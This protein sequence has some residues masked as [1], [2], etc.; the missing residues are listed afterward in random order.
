MW[1]KIGRDR[2]ENYVCGLSSYL[3]Q[4]LNRKFGGS[5]TFFAPDL[6]E[7]TSGLTSINPFDD[8]TDRDLINTLVNRLQEETGYQIRSTNFNLSIGDPDQTYSLRISTHLFHN[9][10]QIDGLVNAM[11]DIYM[12]MV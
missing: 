12:E 2:I 5:G 9:K 3:K 4:K 6:P 7:F 10:K 11:Y 8:V 1:E